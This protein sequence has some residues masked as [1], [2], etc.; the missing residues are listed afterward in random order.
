MRC[1]VVNGAQLKADCCC[2][3]CGKKIG[4]TYLRE[5]RSRAVYCDPECYS[6]AAD[7]SVPALRYL[8]PAA[9]AWRGA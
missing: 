9:N 7:V 8:P 1:I 2:A 6:F 4:D 3:H 5:I